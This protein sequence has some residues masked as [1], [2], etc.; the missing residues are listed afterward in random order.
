[1]KN[2]ETFVAAVDQLAAKWDISTVIIMQ[3]REGVITRKAYGYADRISGRKLC[4]EDRFCL[5]AH[6]NFF[7]GLCLMHLAQRGKIRWNDRVSGCIPEYR[8]GKEITISHLLRAESGIPDDL[9]QVRIPAMQKDARHASL[10]NEEKFQKEF[11]VKA[12]DITFEDVLH[13]IGEKDLDHVPGQE[14]DGSFTAVAFLAE[15]IRRISGKTPRDYLLEEI[16]APLGMVYTCPGNDGTVTPLGCM[17]DDHLVPLPIVHPAHAFTTTLDDMQKLAR[18]LA[19]KRL[20]SENILKAALRLK[21]EWCG[22]G[23]CKRGELYYADD[24]PSP[25]GSFFQ[26]Y[27]YPEDGMSW[28]YLSAAEFI[29]RREQDE[30][31]S[32]PGQVRRIWQYAR[33]YPEKPQLKKIGKKNVW[34]ALQLQILPE[35]HSFVPDAKSCIA[36]TLAC[37][38]PVY[39]L[40]DHGLPIG[41]AALTIDRKKKEYHV[42]YLLVDYRFQGRG[43]GRILLIK[44]IEILKAAGAKKL[45]IGVNRFNIPAQRLYESVG[46]IQDFVYEGFIQMKMEL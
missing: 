18:A 13:L 20:F 15:W 23:I 41:L 40:K 33:A 21:R 26:L 5:S 12:G 31:L 39:V 27:F 8:H 44:A 24:Y 16:F 2:Q 17:G 42:S 10:S 19:E 28:V 45:E 22:L 35:Q 4:T 34:E 36:S 46:F 6:T 29:T 25:M 3:D 32:F 1:M 30:W 11:M 9:Y 38:Q 14:D 7:L 43:Y 37:H